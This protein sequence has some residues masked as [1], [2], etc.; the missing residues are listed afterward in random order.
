MKKVKALR[1]FCVEEA[2]SV[3][4]LG[5]LEGRQRHSVLGTGLEM[6]GT[7]R[8]VGFRGHAYDHP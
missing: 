4:V 6:G 8:R 2:G 3:E 7:G 5:S 1:H